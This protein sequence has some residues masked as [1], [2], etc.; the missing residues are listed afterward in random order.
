M[1]HTKT[2]LYDWS[3]VLWTI[4]RYEK[5]DLEKM[6]TRQLIRLL[7]CRDSYWQDPK[8][9]WITVEAGDY[10]MRQVNEAELREILSRRPHIPN[11]AERRDLINSMKKKSKKNLEFRK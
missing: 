9:E 7:R 2:K 3:N 5:S 1:I 11:K 10:W 6:G 4:D 8:S